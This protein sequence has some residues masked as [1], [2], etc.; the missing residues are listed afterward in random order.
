MASL[1]LRQS[2]RLGQ[3]MMLR[4]CPDDRFHLAVSR[5]D[6]A[7]ELLRMGGESGSVG[8]RIDH[9][10]LAQSVLGVCDVEAPQH[11]REDD[12]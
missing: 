12:E 5:R 1:L 8:R 2:S 7:L 6:A 3:L 4:L 11:A 9:D 10:W